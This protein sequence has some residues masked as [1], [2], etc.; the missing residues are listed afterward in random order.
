MIAGLRLLGDDLVG[1]GDDGISGGGDSGVDSLD[2]IL[3]FLGSS[4]DG[5]L[6]LGLSLLGIVVSASGGADH[7][8]ASD[9]AFLELLF[10][11]AAAQIII[12]MTA[13]DINTFFMV[14]SFY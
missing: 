10:P 2:S 9:S 4:L 7:H 13:A 1:G 14:A 3:D 12:A 6:G 11:Q 5:S 8:R